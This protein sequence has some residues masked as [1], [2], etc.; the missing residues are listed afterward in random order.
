[1]APPAI[2]STGVEPADGSRIA[3]QDG[4]QAPEAPTPPPR[5]D[6][7]GD[8]TMAPHPYDERAGLPGRCWTCNG[9]RGGA[10][11]PTIC[12]DEH[13]FVHDGEGCARGHMRPAD[14]PMMSAHE[15]PP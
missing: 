2:P 14:C 4:N 3:A 5:P 9:T 15:P 7:A 1:G 8:T 6:S 12:R 13:C 11:H 10:S